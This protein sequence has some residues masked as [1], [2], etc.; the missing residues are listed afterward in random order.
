MEERC[1]SDNQLDSYSVLSL[2]LRTK[3]MRPLFSIIIPVFNVAPYLR[4]CLDSVLAQTFIDWEAICIDDG[5]TDGSG[6]ILDEY[7]ARDSRFHVIHQANAGVGAARNR[8]MRCA[9]GLYIGFIDPD[10]VIDVRWL[11]VA[12][13]QIRKSSPDLLRMNFS[14]YKQGL[15]TNRER[16]SPEYNVEIYKTQREILAWGWATFLESGFSWLLFV[17]RR[18]FED[19]GI[20]CCF[21]E[22]IKVRE[23]NIFALRTLPFLE[24]AIYCTY[25]GYFYRQREGSAVSRSGSL[26]DAFVFRRNIMRLWKQAYHDLVIQPGFGDIEDAYKR[27]I[28]ECMIWDWR[29]RIFICMV[30]LSNL[31]HIGI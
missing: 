4:E 25:S 5:S 1:I 10:D 29:R 23:D 26:H 24:K 21:P 13:E 15:I 20:D 3:I 16:I 8:G 27:Q 19:M 18:V 28:E 6:A 9:N 7:A 14:Y 30:R 11:S 12:E 22:D 31:L 17:K 2:R